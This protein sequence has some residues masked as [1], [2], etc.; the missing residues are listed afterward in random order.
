MEVTQFSSLFTTLFLEDMS[1][2]VYNSHIFTMNEAHQP[3]S[4]SAILV[5]TSFGRERNDSQ[6]LE[7]F[8]E[9]V[10]SAG[11]QADL[12]LKVRRPR[13]ESKYLIGSGKATELREQAQEHNISLT[14]I[15]RDLSPGQIRNLEQYTRTRV[16]TYTGLILDIFAQ[17]A[18]S[19]EGKLQVELAQLE[20]LATHLVRGWTHL[21][22]Q[23]GGIG[24]RGPGEK[25][26]ETDRRL[27]K[28]RV[29]TIKNELKSIKLQH[30]Q[31]RRTRKKNAFPLIALVGYTNT[32]KST[33]FNALTS[34]DVDSADMLFAT[35]DPI[36]RRLE[37]ENSVV[38]ISDTVG[39]IRN[40][41]HE[42]IDAFNATLVEVSDADLILCV[43]DASDPQRLEK[44]RCV[45]QVLEEIGAENIKRIRVMNKIDQ[46]SD[47]KARIDPNGDAFVK[48]IYLSALKGIGINLLCQVLQSEIAAKKITY[49]LCLPPDAGAL[50]ASLYGDKKVIKDRYIPGQG[51][52]LELSLEQNDMRKLQAQTTRIR[53]D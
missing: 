25:Q 34:A 6:H 33:L 43:E 22:R 13:P 50:R 16:I 12:V 20:Y 53:N 8:Y 45:E 19:H 18:Q 41:P 44:R 38:L 26:L 21:E 5:A 15:D 48:T 42:L 47:A 28:R 11:I 31:R 2:E 49:R 23:K 32:G 9:L 51:W 37:L 1:K 3:I 36:T 17:R 7:E 30:E 52:L 46:S 35:L 4:E 24:L 40:L 39:F 29:A 27:L 10:A 14:I